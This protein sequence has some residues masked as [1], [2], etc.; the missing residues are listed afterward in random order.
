MRIVPVSDD[1]NE[2]AKGY[3]VNE[4]G[5]I[6]GNE[7]EEGSFGSVP[8][9]VWGAD[10]DVDRSLRVF[11]SWPTRT[12]SDIRQLASRCIDRSSMRAGSRRMFF[13]KSPR[14]KCQTLLKAHGSHLL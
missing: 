12:R 9:W 10:A 14:E 5:S 11:E 6:F 8:E 4:L 13:R 2:V 7:K 3:T 1:E